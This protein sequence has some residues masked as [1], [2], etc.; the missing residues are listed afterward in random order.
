MPIDIDRAAAQHG[1]YE[2]ALEAAGHD[3]V[4]V[5]P[6]PELPDAV[7][8]EDTAVVFDDVAVMARPGAPARR[9]EVGPVAE[10]LAEYRPLERIEAPATL[11]GGDVLRVGRQVWAG[12]ST[13]T[14]AAGIE[15]LRSMVEPRGYTV[16]AVAVSDCLHLKT[17]VTALSPDAVVLH[18]GRVDPAA[19]RDY[20][21]VEVAPGEPEAAN[22]LVL[23]DGAVLMAAGYPDT[24]GRVVALGLEVRTV[25]ISELAKAE[26]GVT[27]CSLLM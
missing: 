11:D 14:N 4:R 18:P 9:A 1:R 10:L 20:E 15:Q 13:R 21:V 5:A 22:V 3:V 24:A 16:E 26:A 6:V 17:A 23:G 27:C 25:E 8:V 19:F 2:R 12:R 7:F